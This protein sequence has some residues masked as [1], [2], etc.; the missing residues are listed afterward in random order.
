MVARISKEAAEFPRSS[1]TRRRLCLW[2][3]HNV[4]QSRQR[5]RL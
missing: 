5:K 1:G 4:D 3:G 2:S